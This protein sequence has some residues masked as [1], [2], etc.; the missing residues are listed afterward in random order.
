MAFQLQ[1]Y[2]V[3]RVVY[4]GTMISEMELT[5]VM[6]RGKIVIKRLVSKTQT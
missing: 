6:G 5:Y 4:Y 2:S 1:L 3:G